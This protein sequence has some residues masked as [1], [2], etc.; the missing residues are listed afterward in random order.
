VNVAVDLVPSGRRF[1]LLAGFVALSLAM[2]AL[3]ILVAARAR[4]PDLRYPRPS[5]LVVVEVAEAREPTP[6]P[7]A[8][9]A[10]RP[11]PPRRVA[12]HRPL[13]RDTPPPNDT[14]P[15][16]VPGPPAPVVVGLT[17]RSTTVAGTVAVPIG[18][19]LMG[20]P[21][22]SASAP[23]DVAPLYLVD[24]QPELLEEVKI[25]YPAEARRLLVAGSVVV[26]LTIDADGRVVRVSVVSGPGHGLNEAAVDALKNFRFRPATRGGKP[27]ATQ[28]VYTYTFSL[29]DD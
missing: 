18:N 9:A 1:S 23:G 10:P 17:L 13:P 19:T 24:T 16:P 25:P 7:P 15:E 20:N 11:P 28:I 14:P 12:T 22:G 8:S 2:H 29:Q 21:G 4:L 3:L 5:E 6:E 27:T 26:R